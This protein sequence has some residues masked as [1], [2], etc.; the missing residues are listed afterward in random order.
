MAKLQRNFIKGK[1]NKGLDERLVP[2]G[3]YI[4]ALNIRVGSTE[5]SEIGAVENSKGNSKLTSLAL[6]ARDPGGAGYQYYDL[7]SDAKCIGAFEDSANETIYWFVTNSNQTTGPQST[8]KLDLIVSYNVNKDIIIYHVVSVDDGGGVNTS[9]NFNSKYL[10]TGV[11]KIGDLLFFTDNYNPPRFIDVTRDYPNPEYVNGLLTEPFQDWGGAVPPL[12]SEAL[13]VIKKPPIN[14][15]TF[16]LLN[17]GVSENFLE[18]KLICFAYRYRYA[19]DMYSATSQFT[20]PAFSPKVFFYDSTSYLNTGM[21]NEFD[22]AEITFNTGGP[23]VVGIDLLFKESSNPVIRI[24]EKLN[25]SE[26]G[27]PDN[28]DEKYT[29]SNNKIYSLLDDNEILRL[30]DNVPL[31]AKAQTVMGERLM[32]GNYIEGYNSGIDLR[33]IL[34]YES[35]PIGLNLNVP[36]DRPTG[37]YNIDVPLVNIGNSQIEIN[38]TDIVLLKDSRLDISV[39]FTHDS[40]SAGPP[41]GLPQLPSTTQVF[42]YFLKQDFADAQALAANQDFLDRIGTA[43]TIQPIADACTGFTFTDLINC[44]IPLNIMDSAGLVW[45]KTGSGIDAQGEPMRVTNG[46]LYPNTINKIRIQ[47][48]A[49]VYRNGVTD[50]FEYYKIEALNISYQEIKNNS[51]LH[52]NRDYEVGIMYMDDFNR[53]TTVLVSP[54]NIVHIPCSASANKNKLK[55]TIPPPQLPPFWAT[56]YKFAIKQDKE[57]YETIY[58]DFYFFDQLTGYTYFLLE[59]ENAQKIEEGDRLTLKADGRGP[60]LTC[61]TITVL[62]KKSQEE[63][64]IN[65]PVVYQDGTNL[66]IPSGV[67]FKTRSFDTLINNSKKQYIDL[68]KHKSPPTGTVISAP[69]IAL[70][71]TFGTP[72]DFPLVKVPVNYTGDFNNPEFLA[73]EELNT[74]DVVKIWFKISREPKEAFWGCPQRIYD[75]NQEYT[76]SQNYATFKDWWEGDNIDLSLGQGTQYIGSAGGESFISSNPPYNDFMFYDNT[77]ASTDTDIPSP[78]TLA[79]PFGIP[80]PAGTG[81]GLMN[82]F[83]FFEDTLGRKFLLIRGSVYNCTI[84]NPNAA[85]VEAKLEIIRGGDVFI[86][87]TEPQKAAPDIFYESSV[88]YPITGGFHTGNVQTQTALL[89]AIIDTEFMNCF[90]FGNGAESYKIRDSIT[91][92]SFG[93]GNRVSAVLEGE[94]Y[95][96]VHRFADITYSGTYGYNV[97][98]LNEFNLGL[99]NFKVLEPTFGEIQKLVGRTT[100]VLTLQEDKISYVLAGKNLLSDA[101][102]GGVVTSVPEVLGTQIARIEEYGIGNN[103]ESFA[104]YGYDKYFTDSKRGVVIQLKGSAYS[105]EQLNVISDFG[106][107]SWF[108]DLFLTAPNNQKL[109]GFDPYMKEYV[110]SANNTALPGVTRTVRGGVM[111]NRLIEGITPVSYTVELGDYVGDCTLIYHVHSVTGTYGVTVKYDGVTKISIGSLSGTGSSTFT[112][113]KVLPNTATVTIT[114]TGRFHIPEYR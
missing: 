10:I 94:D 32:Y 111:Q 62:E 29:F 27:Y 92:N 64:F 109:G 46:T 53:S 100:D 95:R 98:N 102:A 18:D 22:T 83:R 54:T 89:P 67:Y 79:A 16:E 81:N 78:A 110:L 72:A 40:F 56:R 101:A 26:L 39:T 84:F 87:E 76:V 41:A 59:G 28:S 80:T 14:S 106:M 77:L 61:T 71:T 2:N 103:P 17:M 68:G 57:L 113:D 90:A 96:E 5:L 108:R 42:S 69:P 47:L 114:G 93:L 107:S 34:D 91:R 82:C 97:N 8:N 70:I 50:V 65:P 6:I 85:F 45:T 11:N 66:H 44:E 75:F 13:L 112:K 9:L 35:N 48:P 37:I 86:F 30:Y 88:S 12:L 104:E 38:L 73:S 43:T 36:S 99:L 20:N 58:S 51:S 1:M 4:D 3:E 105:N 60:L 25:K 15:P 74:G 52:S 21:E 7:T 55:I 23:L 24:I 19:N 33:Y 49:T 63:D 31:K